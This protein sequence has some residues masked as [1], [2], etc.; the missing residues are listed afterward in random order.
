MSEN[1]V[2]SVL[3]D[4]LITLAH[5]FKQAGMNPPKKIEVDQSDF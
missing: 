3:T 4:A 2:N 1:L 5:A